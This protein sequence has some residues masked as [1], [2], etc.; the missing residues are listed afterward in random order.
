MVCVEQHADTVEYLAIENRDR[1]LFHSAH[2]DASSAGTRPTIDV[3]E[4]IKMIN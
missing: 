2:K 4:D 1:F 3:P